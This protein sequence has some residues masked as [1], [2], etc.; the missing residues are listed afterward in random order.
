MYHTGITQVII[1]RLSQS[2]PHAHIHVVGDS[3][4]LRV[5]SPF[6]RNC[7]RMQWRVGT[8]PWSSTGCR[9]SGRSRYRRAP[10]SSSLSCRYAAFSA[11]STRVG[12]RSIRSRRG[13]GHWSGALKL[14][15][16]QLHD[17]NLNFTARVLL[18]LQTAHPVDVRCKPRVINSVTGT[19]DI[20]VRVFS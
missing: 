1:F 7:W 15:T 6:C 8:A 5:D 19:K 10:A 16:P 2:T 4:H 20:Q 17:E 13:S 12:T 14:V 3:R 9:V 18:Y 11:P